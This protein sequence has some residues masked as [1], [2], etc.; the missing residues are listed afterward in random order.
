[1]CLPFSDHHGGLQIYVDDY[2]QF[3]ITGLKEKVLDV[4]EKDICNSVSTAG[5]TWMM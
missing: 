3:I 2:E 4:A 1:V 5:Y